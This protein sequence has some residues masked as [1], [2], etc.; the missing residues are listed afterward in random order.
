MAWYKKQI[1]GE[2]WVIFFDGDNRV[3]F[4]EAYN[5]L[6]WSQKYR[7]WIEEGNTPEEWVEQ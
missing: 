4:P 5:A 1:D 3:E 6:G 2:Q 7:D